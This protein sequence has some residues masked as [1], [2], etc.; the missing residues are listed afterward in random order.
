MKPQADHS[1]PS[2]SPYAP[3]A[4]AAVDLDGTLL[5][6]GMLPIA[7]QLSGVRWLVSSQGGWVTDI[8]GEQV[9]YT[10]PMPPDRAAEAIEIG[11]RHGYATIAYSTRGIRR[12]S[13]RRSGTRPTMCPCFGWPGSR[14]P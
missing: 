13:W 9:L 8:D 14:W 10:N 2:S 4:V 7:R 6:E 3:F 5:A 12:P 1:S 11:V